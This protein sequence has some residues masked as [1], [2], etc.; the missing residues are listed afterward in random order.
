MKQNQVSISLFL[1]YVKKIVKNVRKTRKSIDLGQSGPGF[2]ISAKN[3]VECTSSQPP[4]LFLSQNRN[5][6]E[7]T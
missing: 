5:F 3:N 7:K 1:K 6:N 2:G 4:A